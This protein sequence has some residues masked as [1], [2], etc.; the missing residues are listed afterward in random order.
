MIRSL[1]A[2]ALLAT[3]V[4]SCADDSIQAPPWAAEIA[5]PMVIDQA[6]LIANWEYIGWPD[7]SEGFLMRPGRYT[8]DF[9][10]DATTPESTEIIVT[11]G[12]LPCQESPVSRVT[13]DDAVVRIDITPGPN[14]VEHCAAMEVRYGLRLVLV[15]PLG[16]RG[17]AATLVDPVNQTELEYPG[18]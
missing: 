1:A 6:G 16:A 5:G 17:V 15:E 2:L 7:E 14:P 9:G 12:A 3:L 10:V 8:G 4:A 13:A 11:W 18:A